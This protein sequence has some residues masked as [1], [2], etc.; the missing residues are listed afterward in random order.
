MFGQRRTISTPELFPVSIHCT[1]P[2]KQEKVSVNISDLV[3]EAKE[4]KHCITDCRMKT[5]EME[6]LFF[7][8]KS[9]RNEAFASIVP[10]VSF[11]VARATLLVNVYN[12]QTSYYLNTLTAEQLRLTQSNNQFVAEIYASSPNPTATQL[13]NTGD[14]RVVKELVVREE[15]MKLQISGTTDLPLA[16]IQKNSL[17][18]MIKGVDLAEMNN[19]Q[20]KNIINDLLHPNEQIYIDALKNFKNYGKVDGC[21]QVSKLAQLREHLKNIDVSRITAKELKYIEDN[22]IEKIEIHHRTSISTDPL[23]QSSID[24][25]NTL[26]TTQHNVKHTDPETGKINYQRKLSE[27]PLDRKAELEAMNKKRVL[28]EKLTGLGIAVAIGAGMGFTIGFITSLAQNGI[29]PNSIKYAFIAGT[30]QGSASVA[31]AVGGYAIGVTVGATAGKALTE[32]V[33]S[34]IGA[35]V[36][37]ETMKK[38][39]EV[40]NN[41]ATGAIITIAFSVYE[42]ARLKHAGYTT[43]ECLLRTGKSA[44]LSFSILIISMIATWYSGP[45]IAVSIVAG[46][47]MVGYSVLKI[48]HD[49]R[50]YKKVTLYSIELCKPTLTMA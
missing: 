29:N 41:G 22:F 14:W 15:L 13:R 20:V 47:I 28:S 17:M 3:V 30:R 5:S 16:D 33:K 42:F 26:T 35:N 44:A 19:A 21:F 11:A 7:T 27:A 10:G 40:C 6:T 31:M 4:K 25:L 32:C 34:W 37:E 18:S 1:D 12:Q 50:V 45:G 46:V 39:G 36:A 23:Q 8:K 2:F 48:R 38:I 9:I 43:R 24:N 49:K